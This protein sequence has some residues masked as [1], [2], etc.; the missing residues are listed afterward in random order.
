[1]DAARG[2]MV[3][4]RS[5]A[6]L[7]RGFSG[8]VMEKVEW[9]VAHPPVTAV[10]GQVVLHVGSSTISFR[11]NFSGGEALLNRGISSLLLVRWYLLVGRF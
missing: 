2:D 1:M 6:Q 3:E 10:H 5:C 8:V 9:R 7:G 11:T 4:R